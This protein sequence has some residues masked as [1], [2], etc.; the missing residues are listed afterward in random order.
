MTCRDAL[1]TVMEEE[2][3]RDPNVFLMGKFS[4][5]PR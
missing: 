2:M 4:N 1:K 3:N 5:D